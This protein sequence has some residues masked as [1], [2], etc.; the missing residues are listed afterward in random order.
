[1]KEMRKKRPIF[2]ESSEFLNIL[3][4]N[5]E[6]LKCNF[7]AFR[8]HHL[9]QKADVICL[10]ETWLK[11]NNEI[12][13]L[14]LDGYNLLHKTRLSSFESSHP[15][16]SQKGGGVAIYFRK[17]MSIKKIDSCEHLNLEYITFEVEKNNT[18]IIICYRS[19]QHSKKEFLINLIEHLEEISI[20]KHIFLIGDFNEDTL[21]NKSKTIDTKLKSLGFTNIFKDLPTTNSLTSLDYNI[22]KKNSLK[23]P[24]STS[25]L[26]EQLASFGFKKV[27]VLGDGNCFFRA[28]SHQLYRH[29]HDHS[30]I[31]SVTINYLI[32]N[33]NDFAPFVDDTDS[34]IENYIERMSRNGTYADH[35][36]ISA[37]AVILNKNII[38]HEIGKT[39][40]LIPGSDFIDHQVHVCYNPDLL[41]Y[42]SIVCVNNESAFLSAEQ[43]L[44]TS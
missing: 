34:T 17:E 35:L 26:F 42:D 22:M 12:D 3:F 25:S 14:E 2:Q 19:P 15:L 13:K 10:A 40:L 4:H 8:R 31:R 24:S 44:F 23:R 36:A 41:H 21:N 29:E 43:I 33:M 39:P 37:T 7:N 1:M 20:E 6:G 18:T 30:N 38:I 28:I 9:T 11:N 32:D 16:H 5:I 27:K